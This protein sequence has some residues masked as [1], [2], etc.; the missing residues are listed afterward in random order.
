MFVDID[1]DGFFALVKD[2]GLLNRKYLAVDVN[3]NFKETIAK[4]ELNE[5]PKKY[6]PGV[7]FHK[8]FTFMVFKDI[9]LCFVALSTGN[10]SICPLVAD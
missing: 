2:G 3:Y 1:I 6:N 9:A 10:F 4:V 7:R 5:T 8:R